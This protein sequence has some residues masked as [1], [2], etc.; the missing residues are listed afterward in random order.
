MKLQSSTYAQ[1]PS[2]FEAGTPAIAEAVGL[3][4]ACD[5]LSSIGMEKIHQHETALGAYLYERL[6][7]LPNVRRY[8]PAA[9]TGL[10]TGLVAFNTPVHATDLAFF[11]DQEGVAIRT[12]HHCAQ[13]LHGLLGAKGSARASLYFYND[14]ND[15]DIFIEKMIH[16]LNMFSDMRSEF[17]L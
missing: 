13:P 6:G 7:E 14:K 1:P 12:G 9:S 10:R 16:V 4:A 17:V 2:R 8:G 5:Y 15:V 3:G 11:L